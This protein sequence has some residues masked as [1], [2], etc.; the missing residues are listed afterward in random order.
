MK[1]V[2]TAFEWIITVICDKKPLKLKVDIGASCY[3]TPKSIFNA[4]SKQNELRKDNSGTEL[5]SCGVHRMP[6]VGITSL[7]NEPDNDFS[8]HDLK[9]TDAG[10][11]FY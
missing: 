9:V 2:K 8:V 4:L 10:D 5:T 11:R 3:V 7:L 1:P 6:V